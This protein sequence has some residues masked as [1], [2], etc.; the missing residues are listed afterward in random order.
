MC[1]SRDEVVRREPGNKIRKLRGQYI[2][3]TED[4][5]FPEAEAFSE[6]EEDGERPHIDEDLLIPTY[7]DAEE[8]TEAI[9]KTH[10]LPF[11]NI[12]KAILPKL[13]F[14]AMNYHHMI[15]SDTKLKT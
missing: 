8:D 10:D 15:N 11:K 7:I 13:K 2:P 1:T 14:H 12:R 6:V 3:N 5:A 9:Q 4:K